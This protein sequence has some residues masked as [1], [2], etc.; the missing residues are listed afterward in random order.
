MI[1]HGRSQ[2][3]KGQWH[4]SFHIFIGASLQT[5]WGKPCYHGCLW[6]AQEVLEVFSC[7]S[8]AGSGIEKF[9]AHRMNNRKAT[10]TRS[11][12]LKKNQSHFLYVIIFTSIIKICQAQKIKFFNLKYSFFQQFCH[13]LDC[14]SWG[15]CNPLSSPEL[16]TS[17]LACIIFWIY[18]ELLW[19]LSTVT[20]W[21][22][23]G[24]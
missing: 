13:P 19:K 8:L 15:G 7:V 18:W 10:P 21:G 3:P 9:L 5:G 11:Y 6:S 12:W 16:A 20:S 23:S 17:L 1:S 24:D 2:T 22:F 14:A 4:D